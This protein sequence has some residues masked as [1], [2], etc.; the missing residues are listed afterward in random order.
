MLMDTAGIMEGDSAHIQ[1]LIARGKDHLDQ[2]EPLYD[3]TDVT[4]VLSMFVGIPY[5][6]KNKIVPG[7]NITSFQ[8]LKI[9]KTRY[10]LLGIKQ[11][12]L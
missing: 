5:N 6:I 12:L 7:I 8:P 1:K 4:N 3:Q 2:V 9:L 11:N 10:L